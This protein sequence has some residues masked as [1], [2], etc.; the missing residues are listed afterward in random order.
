[1]PSSEALNIKPEYH[2]G[3]PATWVDDRDVAIFGD[4]PNGPPDWP[5]IPKDP[6]DPPQFECQASYLDRHGLFLAGERKR[7][8]HAGFQPEI[9]A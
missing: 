9:A 6:A 3:L 5:G 7:L 8:S 4:G 2:L 1:M